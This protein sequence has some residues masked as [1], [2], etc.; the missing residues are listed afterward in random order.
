[1]KAELSKAPRTVQAIPP[2]KIVELDVRPA[3]QAGSEPFSLIMEA[4]DRIPP[5]GALRLRAP[6]EPRPLFRVLEAQGLTHWTEFGEGDDWIIWFYQEEE[7]EEGLASEFEPLITQYPDLPQRL[8]RGAEEWVLDVRDLSL[9][10]PMEMTLA[11]LGHLPEGVRLIQ[12]NQR[13]PQFLL[14]LLEERG[15]RSQILQESENNVRIEIKRA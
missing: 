10:D 6:F 4:V 8:R 14:P 3:L 9:P 13:I 2:E 15:M 11:V 1:M 7:A 5:K 12:I